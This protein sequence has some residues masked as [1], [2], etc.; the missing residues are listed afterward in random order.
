MTITAPAPDDGLPPIIS[1]DQ[2]IRTAKQQQLFAGE[3]IARCPSCGGECAEPEEIEAQKRFQRGWKMPHRC[4]CVWD[5]D[6]WRQYV[7][8]VEA[9]WRTMR[10]QR[11]YKTEENKK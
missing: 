9:H 10:P 6:G 7:A 4:E 5:A 11:D 1:S 3:A 2:L 8:A